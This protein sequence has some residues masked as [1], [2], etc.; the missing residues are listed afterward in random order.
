MALV[1]CKE[2]GK[3]VSTKAKRCPNCGAKVRRTSW[4]SLKLLFVLIFGF[5]LYVAFSTEPPTQKPT[6]SKKVTKPQETTQNP[7]KIDG[8]SWIEKS[9]SEKLEI[10]DAIR[11]SMKDLGCV[12]VRPSDYYVKQLDDFYNDVSINASKVGL[13]QNVIEIMMLVASIGGTNCPSTK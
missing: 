3:N 13:G 11:L 9:D 6:I 12:G 2:C 5:A 8:F 10:A 4:D 1:E 7:R